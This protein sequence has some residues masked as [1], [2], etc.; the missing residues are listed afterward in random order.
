MEDTKSRGLVG[1]FAA[2][3]AEQEQAVLL[4]E[5]AEDVESE[6][7]E[8]GEEWRR[9]MRMLL[10]SFGLSALYVGIDQMSAQADRSRRCC[11]TSYL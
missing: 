4:E 10:Y 7:V 3:E 11:R 9:R 8:K 1:D 2:A 5:R 6:G